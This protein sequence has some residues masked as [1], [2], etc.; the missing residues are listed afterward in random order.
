MT[1]YVAFGD[2]DK[3]GALT[4]RVSENVNKPGLMEKA[5]KAYRSLSPTRSGRSNLASRSFVGPLSPKKRPP[6]IYDQSPVKFTNQAQW[7][8]GPEE[9]EQDERRLRA[10]MRDY[11]ENKEAE[12]MKKAKE[13]YA[14]EVKNAKEKE[15][16]E[17]KRKSKC[18]SELKRCYMN[19]KAPGYRSKY[20]CDKC[21]DKIFNR[22]KAGESACDDNTVSHYK[23][24]CDRHCREGGYTTQ[25]KAKL[26]N[27]K[28]QEELKEREGTYGDNLLEENKG[29]KE[30]MLNNPTFGLSAQHSWDQAYNIANKLER[31]SYEPPSLPTRDLFSGIK[32]P[33]ELPPP[34][35]PPKLEKTTSGKP[36]VQGESEKSP[37]VVWGEPVPYT[38]GARRRRRTKRRKPK[39][40]KK[41]KRT[42]RTR[43]Q[44]R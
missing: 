1:G 39:K 32:G 21:T 10:Q 34:Y 41:S 6:G 37:P 3:P 13:M 43:R 4:P 23:A 11:F 31:R 12:S 20:D 27:K 28:A 35:S 29:R 44:R 18:N 42:R 26:G 8:A 5:R 38:G 9:K 25:M 30:A 36:I 17:K 16:A 7:N 22:V 40:S 2:D 14:E 15:K 33:R 24:D 19:C